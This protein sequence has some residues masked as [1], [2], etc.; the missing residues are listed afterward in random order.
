MCCGKDIIYSPVFLLRTTFR[1][2]AG[3]I[4]ERDHVFQWGVTMP[5]LVMTSAKLRQQPLVFAAL[6]ARLEISN[7]KITIFIFTSNITS[8]HLCAGSLG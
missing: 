4:A 6:P 7:D 2:F 1:I 8:H 5:F 3:A